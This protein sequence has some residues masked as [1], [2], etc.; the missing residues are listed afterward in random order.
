MD[1]LVIEVA[2][3]ATMMAASILF[4]Q[5]I[6]MAQ[7]EY[8]ASKEATKNIVV[9]FFREISRERE[10][11]ETISAAVEVVAERSLEALRI[12]EETR[13]EIRAFSD[14]LD[15][16]V[17]GLSTVR[18]QVETLKQRKDWK[19]EVVE[20]KPPREKALVKTE[21]P[22]SL[23]TGEGGVLSRL[24]STELIVL[25]L[26]EKEGET[27]VPKI[28]ERIGKT[29]EHTA[30]LLKKLYDNGFI[31]RVTGTVPYKYKIRKELRDLL[32]EQ[33]KRD[34]AS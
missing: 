10:R 32:A 3:L 27:T 33:K 24:N 11:R 4:I 7:K 18:G 26:L 2:F 28:R 9:S 34:V 16:A 5:R 23:S 22:P 30:R 17:E 13:S 20:G 25:N 14:K 8:E 21:P 1:F 31:D 6:R 15:K 29:R 19:V 12:S